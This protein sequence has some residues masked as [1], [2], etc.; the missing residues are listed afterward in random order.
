MAG[1]R[2]AG[3]QCRDM[4]PASGI[5]PP[6]QQKLPNLPSLGGALCLL[7]TSKCFAFGMPQHA[8]HGRYFYTPL[9][10]PPPGSLKSFDGLLRSAPGA[11]P[12]SQPL[13]VL[14]A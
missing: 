7:K 4:P 13:P 6:T 9:L 3:S 2:H 5:K 8:P 12:A 14:S 10:G 1:W 11:A